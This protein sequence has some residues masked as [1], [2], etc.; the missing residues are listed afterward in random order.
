MQPFHVLCGI[1]SFV[2]PFDPNSLPP[3]SCSS[4][5]SSLHLLIFAVKVYRYFSSSPLPVSSLLVFVHFSL[6]LLCF[7][8]EDSSLFSLS[9]PLSA[10]AAAVVLNWCCSASAFILRLFFPF[11]SS[12]LR[13]LIAPSPPTSLSAASLAEKDRHQTGCLP[14]VYIK[15]PCVCLCMFS[16][17]RSVCWEFFH[18]LHSC[19]VCSPRHGSFSVLWMWGL[20]SAALKDRKLPCY[21]ILY[22]S[23]AAFVLLRFLRKRIISYSHEKLSV[24]VESPDRRGL[25]DTLHSLILICLAEWWPVC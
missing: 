2:S 23:Q 17:R 22:S 19:T 5:F 4:F 21:T 7:S 25:E 16:V 9:V 10:S 24:S 18:P 15:P 14:P 3:K 12:P 6:R 8:S 20:F 11:L 13:N 1:S